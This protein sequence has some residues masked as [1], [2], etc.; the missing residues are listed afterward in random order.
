MTSEAK[1]AQSVEPM[2]SC[3]RCQKIIK[4]NKMEQEILEPYTYHV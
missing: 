3:G 1:N 4:K 2:K